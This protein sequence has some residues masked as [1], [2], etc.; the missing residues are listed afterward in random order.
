MMT[1]ALDKPRN[2]RSHIFLYLAIA[3]TAVIGVWL[4]S[5]L[6]NAD[7]TPVL[8][9]AARDILRGQSPYEEPLF[10][11]APWGVLLL[12]PFTV[13]PP[14]LARGL[15]FVVTVA[16]YIYVGWRLHAPKVALVALLLSPTAVGALLAANIDAF[17]VPGIFLPAVLGLLVLM[18]KPQI[19]AG[20]GIYYAIEAWRENKLPGVL[21]RFAPLV[22]LTV[23][24]ALLFPAWV[25]RTIWSPQDVW[26]RSIFPFGV[27]IGIALLYLAVR[28]RSKYLALAAG[29][30]LSPYLTFYTYLTV[31]IGLMDPAVEKF[32]RR[33]ILQVVLCIFL[34]AIMLTF[35]L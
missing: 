35:H 32:V 26:N 8:D 28:M 15:V 4:A 27:P 5:Y 12:M 13:L 25:A 6:P 17:V 16:S 1:E 21:R 23:I 30:F 11:T 18:V 22:V 33:D 24:G 29:P 19:G 20:V 14:Q 10:R 9:R 7:W 34:W 2:A 31:Q 3:F